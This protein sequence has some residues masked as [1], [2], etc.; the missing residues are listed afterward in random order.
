ML[1]QGLALIGLP[2]VSG[3]WIF[4]QIESYP[5]DEVVRNREDQLLIRRF[6]EGLQLGL[7]CLGGEGFIFLQICLNREEHTLYYSTAAMRELR[8]S[9]NLR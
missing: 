8:T 9:L 7:S 1:L 5:A 2:A 3:H 6:N 4:H